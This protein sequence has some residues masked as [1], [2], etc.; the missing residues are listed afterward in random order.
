[1]ILIEHSG[2]YCSEPP[3]AI[4]MPHQPSMTTRTCVQ[5][6][7][8]EIAL[9]I[10]LFASPAVADPSDGGAAQPVVTTTEAARHH[11]DVDIYAL[12]SGRCSRLKVAGHEFRC[13]AVAFFHD[14]AGRAQFTVALEDPADESHI[15]S[16]SGENGLRTEDN[17]YELTIDRMLLNSKDRPKV[18]G[19][20]VPSVESSAGLC[21]QTGN[22]AKR[23][24]SSVSCNATDNSGK[25]Y[26]LVFES[27]GSPIIL[28]R[29]RQSK[30]T[31]K[32]EPF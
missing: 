2:R 22:L 30:P 14:E 16:F 21:R 11:P 9:A 15:L 13:R 1:M 4:Y 25:R 19:L 5:L 17:L 24:V 29:V 18:D 26:E 28:R 20:P 3:D 31:I 32:Q 6:L 10:A 7:A 12:M 27:D 23:Q 8:A